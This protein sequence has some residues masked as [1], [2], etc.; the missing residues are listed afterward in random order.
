MRLDERRMS[1]KERAV[2]QLSV[3]SVKMMAE[4]VGV[5]ALPEDTCREISEDATYRLRVIIQEVLKNES[6]Y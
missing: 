3:E 1:A 6:L 5:T 4:S 2:S